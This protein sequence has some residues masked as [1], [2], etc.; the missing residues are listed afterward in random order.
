VSK[1]EET[2]RLNKIIL[3]E[4]INQRHRNGILFMFNVRC[5]I[6]YGLKDFLFEII[7]MNRRIM[8]TDLS[9]N[10]VT[11]DISTRVDKFFTQN[12]PTN[13]HPKFGRRFVGHRV[14]SRY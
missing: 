1:L 8:G 9:D 3:N 7:N 11:D 5:Y 6:T 12:M 2:S 13:N 14:E 10:Y 4:E